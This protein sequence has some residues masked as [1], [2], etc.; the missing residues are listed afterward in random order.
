MPTQWMRL[1]VW[2]SAVGLCAIGRAGDGRPASAPN[3]NAPVAGV[4]SP[5]QPASAAPARD[6]KTTKR[7]GS[8]FAAY[9]PPYYGEVVSDK[10]RDK[11]LAVE[12]EFG[13]RIAA[14]RTQLTA[15]I[16]EQNE[17]MEAVLTAEQ[18]QQIE[19]LRAAANSK[20]PH[21]T[22]ADS[23]AKTKTQSAK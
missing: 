11:I 23:A 2:I 16:K 1:L 14:L 21:A 4:E 15:L 20:R 6:I 3:D 10:Q 12:D 7:K 17:K 18:K 22:S 13:P 8:K 19:Q 9:L 5:G